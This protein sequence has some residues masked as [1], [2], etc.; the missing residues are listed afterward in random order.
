M[1]IVSFAKSLKKAVI[2]PDVL[3]WVAIS[4]KFP[5]G[6]RYAT[7]L[8]ELAEGIRILLMLDAC[9]IIINTT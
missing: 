8:L 4:I 3:G 1:I 5:K 2:P 6:S 7:V 9:L